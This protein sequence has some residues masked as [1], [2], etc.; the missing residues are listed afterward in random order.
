MSTNFSTQQ[1]GSF[2]VKGCTSCYNSARSTNTLRVKSK[3]P[4]HWLML[5]VQE[6]GQRTSWQQLCKT[7]INFEHIYHRDDES[8][9]II[10]L[11]LRQSWDTFTEDY[12]GRRTDIME[13][14]PEKLMTSQEFIGII[15]EEYIW[16]TN[17]ED[18]STNFVI[19]KPHFKPPKPNLSASPTPVTPHK[20]GAHT[21]SAKATMTLIVISST[22]PHHVLFVAW[23]V[24]P[25]KIVERRRRRR[26][27]RTERKGS[28]RVMHWTQSNTWRG[29]YTCT[30][31]WPIKW[32]WETYN[33][34]TKLRKEEQGETSQLPNSKWS[35]PWRTW[36]TG[37]SYH[38]QWQW[39]NICHYTGDEHHSLKEAK[40]SYDWPE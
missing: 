3:S 11:S 39:S 15:H 22:T 24:I 20:N 29:E 36:W 19:Q 16:R 27:K 14:N 2:G 10:S 31:Y 40:A 37:K 28:Q 21:A 4:T 9:V 23:R 17:H 25:T 34:G 35:L 5:K 6:A 26:R 38:W 13:T 33:W 18:E 1:T 30:N 8:R 32:R 12:V 7:P